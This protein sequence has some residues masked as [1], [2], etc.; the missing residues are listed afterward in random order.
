[1]TE[2]G[3]KG[4][5]NSNLLGPRRTPLASVC[6][7]SG[8]ASSKLT[9]SCEDSPM[10]VLQRLTFC[11]YTGDKEAFGPDESKQQRQRTKRLIKAMYLN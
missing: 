1:M 6:R 9:Q 3:I 8:R 4:S 5:E 7:T 2:S 11:I 10:Y